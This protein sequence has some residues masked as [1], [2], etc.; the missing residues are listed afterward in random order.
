ML[1]VEYIRDGILQA[2]HQVAVKVHGD[3]DGRVAQALADDLRLDAAADQHGGVGVA[4]VVEGRFR[5]PGLMLLFPLGVDLPDQAQRR[6]RIGFEGIGIAGGR[7]ADAVA[8]IM[9]QGVGVGAGKEG[10]IGRFQF[11]HHPCG[12]GD[13]GFAKS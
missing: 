2:G 5:H 12:H 3:L 4:E 11:Q 10:L 6:V 13:R 9:L 8:R 7:D 1:L